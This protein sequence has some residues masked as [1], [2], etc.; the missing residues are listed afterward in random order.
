MSTNQPAMAPHIVLVMTDQ[1]RFDTIAALG[2]SHMITPNLDR[3]VKEGVTFTN[4]FVTAPSCAPSRAS[5]FTGYYAHTTG[6]FKNAD[7]WRHTWVERLADSGYHCVNIGKMHTFPYETPAGFHERFVVENKDRYLEGRYFL[8]RWDMALQARGIVKQQRELYRERD[9][10]KTRLGAFEWELPEDMQSDMFV[11]GTAEWWIDHKPVKQPLFLQVG[12]PGPHPPFDPS[13][14][15]LDMYEGRELPLP[16]VTQEELDNQPAAMK[17]LIQHNCD[18]DHD[19]VYW[20]KH[21][22]REQ[23]HRMR[24]H[25][26][27]NV[28]MIDELVGDIIGALERKGM[29]DNTVFIFTSDH[30]EA[31]GDHGH[32]Q[33]WSMYDE[34]TRVPL[35]VWAPGRIEGGRQV[36]A[37]C[38]LFD[39]G[40]TVMELAG[41]KPDP[42]WEARSL[43]AALSVDGDFAGRDYVFSE[44]AYDGILTGTRYMAMIRGKSHKLVYYAEG[45]GELYDLEQDPQERSNRWNDAALSGLK[46]ELQGKLMN[47]LIDSS[48]HTARWA[49]AWR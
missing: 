14:R 3:L 40:P 48:L 33:K 37:L 12:F 38:Q 31:L 8:D 23:L 43:S 47:W 27:A 15:Y 17:E 28:T 10:Y 1:Q 24:Q 21:P 29:L 9:D 39:L 26:C 45:D 7:V 19:S 20:L 49:E 41:L 18:I 46:Q 30:G 6:V 4:C 36:D 22:T 32:I 2:H 34:V 44:H 25:Y 35:I 13:K 42:S 11:G 5:L 16:R